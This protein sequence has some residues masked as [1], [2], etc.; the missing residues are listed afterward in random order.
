M[1]VRDLGALAIAVDAD[2]R[3]VAGVRA[4]AML[5]LLTINANRRVSVDALTD[6]AWGEQ[7]G[8][9]AG[10]SLETHIWR[11]RQLLEPGRRRRQPPTVLVNDAGG[12][13]LV[14]GAQSVD[15][16]LFGELAGEV[17]DLLAAGHAT[18]AVAKA[19]TA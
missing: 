7:A 18:A 17:R 8:T 13:R 4:T 9:G 19:D 14:A 16:L 12:Y 2:E 5:A 10:S 11:L 6:A 15:S 1:R 3:P